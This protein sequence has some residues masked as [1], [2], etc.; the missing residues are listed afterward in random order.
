MTFK[1]SDHLDD[2]PPVISRPEIS[3][4][5]PWLSPK[6][7]ANL[8]HQGDGPPYFRNGRIVLYPIKDLLAWLD[9]RS[10]PGAMGEAGKS[11]KKAERER[12]EPPTKSR[13]GRK[14]KA[15]EVKE[16]RSP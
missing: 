10:E 1:F 13:R 14:T 11:T 15:Q 2:Y 8:V 3:K 16:R 7:M 4:Y 12:R 5:F 9:S 6:Y